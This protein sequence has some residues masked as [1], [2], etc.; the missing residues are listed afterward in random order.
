[1]SNIQV[2]VVDINHER[3]M[4]G[5]LITYLFRTG[6]EEIVLRVEK[7]FFNE[8]DRYIQNPKLFS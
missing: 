1:M 5:T 4:P 8:V 6:L 3:K 2:A 7:L